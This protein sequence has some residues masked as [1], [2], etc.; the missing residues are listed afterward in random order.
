[1]PAFLIRSDED[2][3]LF[4]PNIMHTVRGEVSLFDKISHFVAE[5]EHHV[6]DLLTGKDLFMSAADCRPGMDAVREALRPLVAIRA[7]RVAVPSLDLILTPNGFGVVQNSNTAPASRDRVAALAGSLLKREDEAAVRLLDVLRG[8]PLWRQSREGMGWRLSLLQRPDDLTGD[9]VA[10]YD[11]SMPRWELLHAV[12]PE[13]AA[14]EDH[15]ANQSIS[16]D[17]LKVL[18]HELQAGQLN[19]DRR[20]AAGMFAGVVRTC[21]DSAYEIAFPDLP[22]PLR[23]LVD[24]VSRWPE[25][26]PEWRQ[27]R[28]AHLFAPA[29]FANRRESSGYF[30]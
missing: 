10:G 9:M 6:A 19:V 4:I 1:M 12:M 15:L 14:R 13:V 16:V 24:F 7:F 5:T 2:L 30:F 18:R 25:T 23:D 29:V 17:L 3:R 26:F 22:E 27:S 21:Y 8:M 11:A 20:A 28:T